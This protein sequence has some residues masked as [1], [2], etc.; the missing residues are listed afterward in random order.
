MSLLGGVMLIALIAGSVALWRNNYA[1]LDRSYTWYVDY[2]AGSG[3]KVLVRGKKIKVISNDINKIII[4]LNRTAIE[5]ETSVVRS[6]DVPLEPPKL[7]LQKVGGG[8]AY[9]EVINAEYLTQRMGT[10]G[11]Q[12]YLAAA[13]FSLT[14]APGVKGVNFAFPEGDHAMPGEYTRESFKDYAVAGK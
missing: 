3:R 9:I 4:A 1:A 5:A 11:A 10:S 7:R 2:D 8:I 14:E 13:T 6:E 12:N